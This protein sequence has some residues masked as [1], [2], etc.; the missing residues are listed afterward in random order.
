MRNA[1]IHRRLLLHEECH[2]LLLDREGQREALDRKRHLRRI[3][4]EPQEIDLAD[5]GLDAALQLTHTPLL[6]RKVLDDVRDNLLADANLLKQIDL[7]QRLAD[8]IV[9]R[10]DEL[11]LEAE[12]LH[13]DIVHA[14]AEN[15]VHAT[16]V[17]VTEYKE[18]AAQIQV[19]ARKVLVLEAIVLGSVRQVDEQIVNLLTLGRI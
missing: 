19:D 6:A 1:R 12:A 8:E 3:I 14:V 13:L 9:L 18:A 11:L 5:H 2:V 4:V 16:V 17:I 7:T 10:D 15:R